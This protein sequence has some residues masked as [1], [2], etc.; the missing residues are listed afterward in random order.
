MEEYHRDSLRE[1]RRAAA[2]Q[3]RPAKGKGS[4]FVTLLIILLFLAAGGFY[5]KTEHPE[6]LEK[7]FSS[8]AVEER[9]KGWKEDLQAVFRKEEAEDVQQIVD[10]VLAEQNETI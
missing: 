3:E 7:Y 8:A 9:L 5:L 1:L 4:L 10:S 6:L 2:E